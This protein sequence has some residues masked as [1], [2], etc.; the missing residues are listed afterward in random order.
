M[1]VVILPALSIA[2]SWHITIFYAR[3]AHIKKC[4]IKVKQFSS[5]LEYSNSYQILINK[6]T[7]HIIS[8]IK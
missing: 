2:L 6:M 3:T 1:I 4:Y 8:A 7:K 5:A